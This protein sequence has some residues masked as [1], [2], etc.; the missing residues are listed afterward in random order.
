[1]MAFCLT[2]DITSSGNQVLFEVGG[3]AN[4][5][6]IHITGFDD[7]DCMA[8]SSNT[9]RSRV[10]LSNYISTNT[11]YHIAY[12]YDASVPTTVLYINGESVGSVLTNTGVSV[13][14]SLNANGI[15]ASAGGT[16]N[17]V[18]GYGDGAFPWRGRIGD[19]AYFDYLLTQ[20]QVRRIARQN[21]TT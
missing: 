18:G 19:V 7:F 6:A 12:G 16:R 8:W 14:T 4:G 1:M 15:G 11:I 21:M 13:G 10:L 17:A 5:S 3:A 2:T 20:S 9:I